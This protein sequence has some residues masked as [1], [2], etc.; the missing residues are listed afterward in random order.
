MSALRIL[1]L[2]SEYV[3]LFIEHFRGKS[4]VLGG[5]QL[6][7]GEHPDFNASYLEVLDC[8]GHPFL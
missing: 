2:E 5:L 6:I 3:H 8:L 7:P 1:G 4:N